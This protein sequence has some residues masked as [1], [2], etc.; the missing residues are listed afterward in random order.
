MAATDCE[1]GCVH[2]SSVTGQPLI[3]CP[4]QCWKTYRGSRPGP[5]EHEE[6]LTDEEDHLPEL[7]ATNST[8][9]GMS[10]A[11]SDG[12]TKKQKKN[13]LRKDRKRNQV[14]RDSAALDVNAKETAKLIAAEK[15]KANGLARII[16]DTRWHV[17]LAQDG[18]RLASNVLM[19]FYIPL[20][21]NYC[22][23]R[24]ILLEIEA[25]PLNKFKAMGGQP[26]M[27]TQS[28]RQYQFPVNNS[29]IPSSRLLVMIKSYMAL[30]GWLIVRAMFCIVGGSHQYM[31]LDRGYYHS[32]SLFV[33]I[34]ARRVRFGR[35]GGKDFEVN[36][37][38]GDVLAFN[39]LVWHSGL[40]NDS[41]SCVVFMYFDRAPFYITD[42]MRADETA[43]QSRFGFTKMYSEEQWVEYSA[44][45]SGDQDIYTAVQLQNLAMLPTSLL[46][47]LVPASE[48]TLDM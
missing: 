42:E 1:N 48:F 9:G 15:K 30:C 11:P 20:A 36:M 22:L 7:I 6:D 44:S 4:P 46:R 10:L 43:D 16:T 28:R 19:L 35:R 5:A 24:D 23:I 14:A 26:G 17:S 12:W 40:A 34:V 8:T 41:D 37:N 2:A 18:M 25:I 47:A 39:G 45:F 33:C 32:I 27:F 13:F 31:H 29:N 21:V 3:S 38:A